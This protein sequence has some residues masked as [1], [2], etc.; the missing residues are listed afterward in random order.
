MNSMMQRM[1][2][3]FIEERI[4]ASRANHAALAL[5]FKGKK[6]KAQNIKQ[7]R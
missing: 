2:N 3:G 5:L 1:L 4:L 6:M 7:R